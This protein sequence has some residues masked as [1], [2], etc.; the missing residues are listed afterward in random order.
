MYA[1]CHN[2][3]YTPHQTAAQAVINIQEDVHCD[4]RPFPLLSRTEDGVLHILSVSW[5]A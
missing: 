2:L 4:S 3:D 5:T 1:F